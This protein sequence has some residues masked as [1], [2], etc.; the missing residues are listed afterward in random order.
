MISTR[1]YWGVIIIFFSIKLY[2][3]IE[4]SSAASSYMA[5]AF[6]KF[7]FTV[8]I[9]SFVKIA[10]CNVFLELDPHVASLSA[11]EV[12]TEEEDEYV[13]YFFFLLFF[14]LTEFYVKNKYI[15]GIRRIYRRRG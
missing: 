5:S 14:I 3:V 9:T 10:N 12:S 13:A 1:F 4:H 7:T 6:P 8:L 2:I 11:L 15:I